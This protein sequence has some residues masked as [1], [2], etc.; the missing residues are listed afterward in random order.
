MFLFVTACGQSDMQG[1][2]DFAGRDIA[3]VLPGETRVA[4]NYKWGD[5]LS[6]WP[7]VTVSVTYQYSPDNAQTLTALYEYNAADRT[8]TCNE[9]TPLQYPP[10]GI[11]YRVKVLWPDEGKRYYAQSSYKDQRELDDF[12]L[13]DFLVDSL[14]NP[15]PSKVL[16]LLFKHERAQLSFHLSS[17]FIE[18]Q[19]RAFEWIDGRK[20]YCNAGNA[21]LIVDPNDAVTLKT[22]PQI[23][24]I[25]LQG[26]DNATV[27][28]NVTGWTANP[29]ENNDVEIFFN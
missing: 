1:E 21:H 16:P 20:A 23:A 28:I 24:V 27:G 13:S 10:A 19:I 7:R 12:L 17:Q 22:L 14:I 4:Q 29:G 15:A 6:V 25:Q 5:Y 8:L 9:G 3:F 2:E 18:Q 11:S 26:R